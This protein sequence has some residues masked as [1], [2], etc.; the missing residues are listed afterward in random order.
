MV[1][2]LSQRCSRGERED[3][4]YIE[5][6]LSSV[7]REFGSDGFVDVPVYAALKRSVV[8]LLAFCR[9]EAFDRRRRE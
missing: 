7:E 6:E 8:I 9:R 1:I 2:T 3:V 5:L 4:L